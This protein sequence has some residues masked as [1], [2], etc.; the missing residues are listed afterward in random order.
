MVLKV[1]EKRATDLQLE[2][3]Q[4]QH[5]GIL[6]LSGEG[7]AWVVSC[8]DNIWDTNFLPIFEFFMIGVEQE[9]QEQC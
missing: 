5:I 9:D 7:L 2:H 3:N 4:A 1:V 8:V 6:W